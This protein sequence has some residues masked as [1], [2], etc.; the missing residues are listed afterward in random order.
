MFFRRLSFLTLVFAVVA[1]GIP[2]KRDAAQV[3]LDIQNLQAQSKSLDE[4]IQAFPNSG[5]TL[6]QI[7][8]SVS[9]LFALLLYLYI[10]ET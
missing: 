10:Y 4:S 9:L 2:V 6:A 7:Y 1:F 8:V 5:G 3:E